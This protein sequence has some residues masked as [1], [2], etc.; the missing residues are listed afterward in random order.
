[1]SLVFI[2]YDYSEN[3]PEWMLCA[4]T[5]DRLI[6]ELEIYATRFRN[7]EP[8]IKA[9]NELLASKTDEELLKHGADDP[10]RGWLIWGYRMNGE[11]GTTKLRV[12]YLE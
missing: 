1:M 7:P 9:V 4:G 8:A 2:L 11:W 10:A 12:E 5:R 6:K 3:G